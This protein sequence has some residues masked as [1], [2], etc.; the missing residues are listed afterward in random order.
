MKIV[1]LISGN[2]SNLQAIIDAIEQGLNVEILAVI[3][4]KPDVYGLQRAAEAH[5]PTQVI[6]HSNYATRNEF[7]RALL[8]AIDNYQPELI[9]LAGFMR[10]L[11]SAFIAHYQGKLINIHPSLLPKYRGLDTHARVLVAG[12]K[13]HGATVHFVTD[14]LDG[15]PIIAQAAVPVLE[16][17]TEITLKQ[18]VLVAEHLLYPQVI[19]W[20][21]GQRVSLQ[22]EQVELDGKLVSSQGITVK[23]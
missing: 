7:D 12:D 3:S 20:F 6:P 4:N 18:R 13:I 10:H 1:V 16:D 2:G 23:I 22:D 19:G 14:D 15:G 5:I 11:G 21:A 9:V 17:D 8:T